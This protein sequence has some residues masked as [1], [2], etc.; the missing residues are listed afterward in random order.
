MVVATMV[1]RTGRIRVDPTEGVTG[2]RIGKLTAEERVALSL[3]LQTYSFRPSPARTGV[4]P[5]LSD[6]QPYL[7]DSLTLAVED[8][9]SVLAQASA[10]PMRQNVRGHVHPMGGVAGVASH[11][12]HRGRGHVRTLMNEL[13]GRMRD[14]GQAVSAMHPFRPSFYQRF[15]Y[16]NLPRSRTVRFS[17]T[18]LAPLLSA[19]L[20]GHVTMTR[21]ADGYDTYRAYLDTVMAVRHGFAVL[22]DSRSRQPR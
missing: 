22:P 14:T 3:P 4:D 10:I 17:P 18:G 15:G 20:P 1:G 12:L 16:V 9:G 5:Y 11:P 6:M 7:G 2:M 21:I 13:L 19:D 8:G